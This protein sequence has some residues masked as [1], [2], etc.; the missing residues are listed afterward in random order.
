LIEPYF[1][2]YIGSHF[3][4]TRLMV[5]SES[6]YDW[7][8]GKKLITPP[9][10]HPTRSLEHAMAN[11][12]TCATYFVSMSRALCGARK[13]TKAEMKAAWGQCAYTI[14]VQSTVGAGAR[15]RPTGRQFKDAGPPFLS[16]LERLRPGKVIVTGIQLWKS[17]P[18]TAVQLG[19]DLQAYKLG[20]GTLVW[21]L[22]VPHPSNSR[23]GFRWQD[24]NETIGSFRSKNLP[25]RYKGPGGIDE[26]ERVKEPSPAI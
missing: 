9:P 25:L 20:D 6:A 19:N 11:I 16:V 8:E 13:P 2:P 14:F 4:D 17:M 22:A 10:A 26:H 23:V 5:L 18:N 3:S 1:E 24:V 15:K 7:K 21:C 12:E